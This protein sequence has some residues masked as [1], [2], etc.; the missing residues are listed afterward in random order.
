MDNLPA[1]TPKPSAVR[2]HRLA[3]S[4]SFVL[5]IQGFRS[6]LCQLIIGLDPVMLLPR[7]RL[8]LFQLADFDASLPVDVTD[9]HFEGLKLI[10]TRCRMRVTSAASR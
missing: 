8:L 4:E 1:W 5:G 6:R 7:A 3:I 10:E 2:R 9:A